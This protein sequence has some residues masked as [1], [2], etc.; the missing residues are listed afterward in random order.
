MLILS[1]QLADKSSKKL[2]IVIILISCYVFGLLL[3]YEWEVIHVSLPMDAY[4]IVISLSSIYTYM[5]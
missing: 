2:D 1:L 3:L 5:K 4:Y